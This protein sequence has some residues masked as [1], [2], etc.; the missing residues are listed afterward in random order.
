MD[1][2]VEAPLDVQPGGPG[3]LVPMAKDHDQLFGLAA[4]SN[5]VAA[6]IDGDLDAP[7][8]IGEGVLP[9][10][11]VAAVD[12][13]VLPLDVP[14]SST[15]LLVHGVQLHDV[16]TGDNDDDLL[17]LDLPAGGGT[18]T[19]IAID[20]NEDDDDKPDNT[21]LD[22]DGY[23]YD[24]AVLGGDSYGVQLQDVAT[25]DNE[26]L[27]SLELPAG[28]GP[29]AV[30]ATDDGD[31]DNDSE[32]DDDDSDSESGDDEVPDKTVPDFDYHKMRTLVGSRHG[33]QDMIPSTRTQATAAN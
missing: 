13:G 6:S 24:Y 15:G 18:L 5:H 14:D 10:Q 17:P 32:S 20:D 19:V 26:D 22:Y 16:T 23:I 11:V 29:L 7:T 3:D 2:L 12:D 27:L 31:E 30:I 1:P 21:D 28:G 33:R 4:E 25:G 9:L 8:A